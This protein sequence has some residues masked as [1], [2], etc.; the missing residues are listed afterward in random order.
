MLPNTGN[1][2]SQNFEIRKEPTKTYQLKDGRIRGYADGLEAMRQSV[3]C[4][5]N[6]ER[7]DYP[8][9]SW[10]YGVELNRLYGTSPG[11]IQSKVKKRISEALRQDDRIQSVGAFSFTHTGERLCVAFTVQTEQGTIEAEKEVKLNV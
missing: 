4:I 11:L 3:Q 7:F 2:L 9:Y 8:I 5:L 6:T 1:I 10:N